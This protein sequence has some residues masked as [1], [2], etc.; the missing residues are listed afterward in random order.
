MTPVLA[1]TSHDSVPAAVSFLHHALHCI[2]AD[3][4]DHVMMPVPAMN[5]SNPFCAVAG[6]WS[7][8]QVATFELA[9]SCIIVHSE[10]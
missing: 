10:Y 2:A 8:A 4:Q 1:C 3:L 9:E 6:P 7:I 5:G